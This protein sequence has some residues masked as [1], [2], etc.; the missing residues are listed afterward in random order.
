MIYVVVKE[1]GKI[2]NRCDAWERGGERRMRIEAKKAGWS[3]TGVE[4]TFSGD[5]VIWVA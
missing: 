3:V 1:T 2:V 4:I 5:M